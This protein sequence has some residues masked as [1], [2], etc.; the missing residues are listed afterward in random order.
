MS[1]TKAFLAAMAIACAAAQT[2]PPKMYIAVL[3][4]Y[5]GSG[6]S[7]HVHVARTPDGKIYLKSAVTGLGAVDCSSTS[8]GASSAGAACGQHIHDG[9]ACT[10]VTTQGGHLMNTAGTD[11]WSG[12]G[13][14]I[15]S[16]ATGYTVWDAPMVSVGTDYADLNGKPFVVHGHSGA[17]VACGI[18]QAKVDPMF[19]AQL[20]RSLAHPCPTSRAQCG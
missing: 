18:L 2:T 9:Y 14:S 3:S 4:Q 13:L 5:A 11:P 15:N 12:T 17:R 7:G 16:S 1:L 20:P 10:N 19:V 8:G 6:V